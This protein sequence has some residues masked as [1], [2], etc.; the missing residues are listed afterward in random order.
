MQSQYD[1]EQATLLAHR[2]TCD[3]KD[4]EFEKFRDE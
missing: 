3:L 4:R 2:A 1:A